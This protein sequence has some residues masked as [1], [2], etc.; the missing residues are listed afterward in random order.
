MP[1]LIGMTVV[2]HPESGEVVALSGDLPDWA[3]GLV[4]EHLLDAAPDE[5][6]ATDEGDVK[7]YAGLVKADLL[8]LIEDR[9]A[10]R[11]DESKVAPESEKNDD[12]IA[13]L[14]ADD[15]RSAAQA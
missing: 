6:D 9:N 11:S 5:G 1:K 2:R 8:K 14:V 15:A 3:A 7:P 4:G 13:A 10:G 12:L